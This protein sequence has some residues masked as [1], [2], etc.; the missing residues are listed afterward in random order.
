M[1]KFQFKALQKT[2][3][4][5]IVYSMPKYILFTILCILSILLLTAL[6]LS[7]MTLRYYV[8]TAAIPQAVEAVVLENVRISQPDGSQKTLAQ[9]ILDEYIQDD[10]ISVE[11]VQEVLHDGTFSDFAAALAEQYNRYLADGGQF[12][13][14]DSQEFVA[15][16]EENADLIYQKT[17]LRF[18]DPDKKKLQQNLNH[19]LTLVNKILESYLYKGPKGFLLRTAL[20]LWFQILLILLMIAALAWMIVI[21]IRGKRRIG[22]AFKIYSVT[23]FVPCFGIFLLGLLMTWVL[24]LMKLPAE[25]G[26]ALRGRTVTFSG[27]GM[28]ICVM[29][30]CTG[31]LWNLIAVKPEPVQEIQKSESVDLPKPVPRMQRQFCRYCGQKLSDADALFCMHCGKVQDKANLLK[32]PPVLK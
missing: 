29:L 1:M 9:Y 13:E 20:S 31:M 22:T 28:L 25:L 30:F 5:E 32:K 26:T 15:L 8:R 11:E 6:L 24:E 21:H 4:K 7:C 10:R 23:A 16:L 14:I 17:G 3:K 27:I 2:E 12:P 18:L 19:P